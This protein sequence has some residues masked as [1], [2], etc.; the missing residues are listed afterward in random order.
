MDSEVGVMEPAEEKGKVAS[1]GGEGPGWWQQVLL[2]PL[3]S[4]HPFFHSLPD[5][6]ATSGEGAIQGSEYLLS[7]PGM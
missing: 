5:T 7:P 4:A 2:P 3:T 1:E 6:E